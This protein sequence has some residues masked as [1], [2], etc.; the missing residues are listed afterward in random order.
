[1]GARIS[2][3]N[4]GRSLKL[5]SRQYGEYL[6]IKR[7]ERRSYLIG[8][9]SIDAIKQIRYLLESGE[10]REQILDKLNETE[11]LNVQTNDEQMNEYMMNLPQV[12]RET[13]KQIQSV[14][15]NNE[16]LIGYLSQVNE[17][18]NKYESLLNK[19]NELIHRLTE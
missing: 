15:E 9:S 6:H 13:L 8:E 4:G 3:I 17:R 1:M 14:S 2:W 16:Q 19:Q 11:V 10:Q 5:L 18:V 7:G 12:Q